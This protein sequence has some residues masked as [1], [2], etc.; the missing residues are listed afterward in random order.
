MGLPERDWLEYPSV[1]DTGSPVPTELFHQIHQALGCFIDSDYAIPCITHV[2]K[3][4]LDTDISFDELYHTCIEVSAWLQ[5][6]G[7]RIESTAQ[8]SETPN[9]G[10]SAVFG[11]Q[12]I[13]N[14]L[15]PRVCWAWVW[16]SLADLQAVEMGYHTL[17]GLNI[18][19]KNLT[20]NI[21]NEATKALL[22]E[23]TAIMER[24]KTSLSQ[25]WG[26]LR[27]NLTIRYANTT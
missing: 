20:V 23:E 21:G 5:I 9:S 22:E 27:G 25:S 26:T 19:G 1:L 11:D 10:S 12:A 24:K 8:I 2:F 4:S 6:N 13:F 18:W 15:W 16:N 7:K 14:C 3:F 17:V